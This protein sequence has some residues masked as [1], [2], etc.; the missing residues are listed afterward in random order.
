[1]NNFAQI[2]DS[3]NWKEVEQSIYSKRED[4]VLR[5]LVSDKLT[6]EDFKALISPAAAPF[7]EQ[8]TLKSRQLTLKRFGNTIQLYAPMY[9]SNECNNICVYCGFSFD[10]KIRRRTLTMEEISKEA[11]AIKQM[12]FDHIL[13]VTGEAFLTVN[14]PYFTK[15]I[16]TIRP[17]FSNISI[18][19]QPLEAEE[20]AKLHNEGLYAVLV[21]QETYNKENYKNYHPK[22]KK[23]NF[24]YRLDTPDRIGQAGI[25]KTGLGV[26]LGLEDWRTDSFFCALHLDY[27]TKKYWQ[28]KYS[29]SFPRIR[30]AEGV[31]IDKKNITDK[32]LVQL[33]TTYRLFNE[34]V[35]LSM[36]T[37]ESQKFRNNIIKLGITSM[38]AGSKTNP[39]GYAVEPESLKQFDIDDTRTP[40]EMVEI[41]RMQGYEPVWKDWFQLKMES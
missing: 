37:R 4:D 41:I 9:L 30:P 15:A 19:V 18:E 25:H 36:S 24:Y 26:L 10:N 39:G 6:P 11:A 20:Y 23:S 32:E 21:Y 5:A 29:I 33:I 14:L 40:Q 16:Q 27:L 13:L 7:L 22:G 28:T 17:F 12:G 31:H 35:E 34:D 3:Y 38:S 8:M 1:M 2:F